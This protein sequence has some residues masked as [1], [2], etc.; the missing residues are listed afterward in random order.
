MTILTE[1]IVPLKNEQIRVV[2]KLPLKERRK[3]ALSSILENAEFGL[4]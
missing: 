4:Y 1:H 3:S 2:V